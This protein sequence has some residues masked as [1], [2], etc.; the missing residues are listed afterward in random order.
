[1]ARLAVRYFWWRALSLEK[2]RV[3]NQP[4]HVKWTGKLKKI[5]ILLFCKIVMNRITLE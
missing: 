1:V 3:W 4:Y 5:V 2:S